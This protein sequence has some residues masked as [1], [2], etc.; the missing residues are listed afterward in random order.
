MM[1][2]KVQKKNQG[3][4]PANLAALKQALRPYGKKYE[5]WTESSACFLTPDEIRAVRSYLKTKSYSLSSKKLRVPEVIFFIT[6][7]NTIT[8]LRLFLPLFKNWVVLDRQMRLVRIRTN[9]EAGF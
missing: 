7:K 4:L 6:I 3:E 2:K 1:T 9:K 8:K 5:P